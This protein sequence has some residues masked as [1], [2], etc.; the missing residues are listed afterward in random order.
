M[1]I[2]ESKESSNDSNVFS[3]FLSVRVMP[4]ILHLHQKNQNLLHPWSPECPI[5]AAPLST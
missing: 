1:Q 2:S 5:A 3:L 4:G